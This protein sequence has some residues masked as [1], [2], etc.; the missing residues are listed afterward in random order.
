MN[1]GE[2]NA[3]TEPLRDGAVPLESIL[4]TEELSRRRARPPDYQGENRALSA[5]AKALADSPRTILQ[6]LADTILEVFQADS[7]GLS[8]LTTHDGGRRF[9]WPAIAGAWKAH[10]G[11]GTPREFGPCGDVLDRNAPLLFKHF[12]RRYSYLL[13]ATPAAV[14]AL[15]IPFYVHGKAVGTIWAMAHDERRRFDAED[16]RQ[17][18]SLG[19]FAS[20]A[21]QVAQLSQTD[22]SR[23]AALNL[24]EDAVQ[25]R[26]TAD[27]LNGELRESAERYRTLFD[28]GPVAVY[29]CDASGVIREFNRRAAELWG[30][31]PA[32][33]DAAERFCGSFR[34]IRPDGSVLAHAACPMADVLSG[35]VPYARDAE[36]GI[37][38]PDGS[39]IDV[40]VNIRPLKNARGEITGAINCF[41]DI[42]QRKEMEQQLRASE[43]RYRTLTEQVKDYAI[44]RTDVKGHALTWNQG[45]ERILGLSE[46]EFLGQ[47]IVETIFTPEDIESGVAQHELDTAAAEGTAA[48][49]HWMRR[50][51]GERFFA[52]G[53]TTGLRNDRGELIGFTK[54]MRDVTDR[55]Q[56]ES[57]ILCQKES[58]ELLLSGE[59]IEQVLDFLARSM[60]SQSQGGFL[61]AIHLMEADGYHFGYV[62]APSLP[63]SYARMTRGMD[64]RLELGACSSAVV[65]H[66][67][68]IVRDFA[69]ETR[70]P[71]F[72]AEMMALGLRACF[73]TPI[74]PAPSEPRILGTFALY[75]REPRGPSPHDQRLVD[76]VTHT[77]ALAID[78]KQAE[79]AL[80]ESEEH[81]AAL[82]REREQ[83][84][85]SERAARGE[86]E[87]A[88]RVKDDFLATLSHE[89]RTPLSNVVSWSRVLQKKYA[90]D[91]EQLRRGLSIIANNAMAQAQIV[92]DLLDMSRIVSGKV[93]VLPV[94]MLDASDPVRYV[95]Q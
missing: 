18:E 74:L 73:T 4:C 95:G 28:L 32:L 84:L 26:C 92:G 70:W 34:M 25:A 37:E 91:D 66:Q 8:L 24:M 52:N 78:R 10:V 11:G 12:E 44:F 56:A 35:A 85:E 61:T 40:V 19:R 82:A 6:T 53:V 65:A 87:S 20:A 47:D 22:D 71:E 9:Y 77:V 90:D 46:A 23:R 30:R 94:R 59:P 31:V 5:L 68:A 1:A 72:T 60:E 86:A 50:R 67:P 3:P 41:Y 17:L 51:N 83:L 63:A 29:S 15:L 43:E 7:A 21:Y 89:L 33:G 69:Q 80:R 55:K 81:S 93:R 76:L 64:A 88:N 75:Y 62:A 27:Q 42:T 16:L 14:E 2:A 49:D 57:L 36:V 79:Q 58:L 48:N 45:V 54:V 38:R 13:A 39:R